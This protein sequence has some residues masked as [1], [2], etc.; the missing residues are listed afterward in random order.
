MVMRKNINQIIKEAID[1]FIKENVEGE[2]LQTKVVSPTERYVTYVDD[3]KDD[4]LNTTLD[5]NPTIDEIDINGIKVTTYSMFKRI[6]N[7][8]GDGNPALYALKNEKNWSMTNLD[9]FWKRFEE[10]TQKFVETH[11]NF[12]TIVQIPSTNPLNDRIIQCLSE[13]CPSIQV[14]SKVIHKLTTDEVL[15]QCDKE[16]SFFAEYWVNDYETAYDRLNAYLSVMDE[17]NEGMFTYHLIDDQKMRQSIINTMK[18][19]P[20]D[21]PLYCSNINDK[22]IIL[23]DDSIT[24]G[25]SIKSACNA[26]LNCYNPKSISIFTMFSRLYK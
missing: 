14:L 4:L 5:N 10:I 16:G 13:K 8:K 17:K 2:S 19:I 12:S 24:H 22:D 9:E 25:Q 18:I 6:G 21:F 15:A 7:K 11:D 3:D 20:E 23:I 26:L 1:R